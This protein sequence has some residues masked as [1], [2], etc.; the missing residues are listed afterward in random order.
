M[1]LKLDW[2]RPI[3]LK[4]GSAENLIYTCDHTKL[5]RTS[6]IYV[7]GRRYGTKIE[8]L[9]VGK[10][11]SLQG[12]VRGQFK[13]LPLMLHLQNAKNGKRIILAARFLSKP[14]QNRRS[15][16][17]YWSAHSFDI[18]CRR[19]TIS[20]TFKAPNCGATKLHRSGLSVPSRK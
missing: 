4:N 7:F 10:A 1:K 19:G 20:L 8:A 13:N 12:R 11:D 2:A 5:P 16:S 3:N 9:Y 17:L 15:A 6:G 14:G 18:F